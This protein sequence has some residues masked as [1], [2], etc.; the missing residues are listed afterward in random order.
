MAHIRALSHQHPAARLKIIEANSYH[1]DLP[2]HRFAALLYWDDFGVG[3]DE[4]QRYLLRRIRTWLQPE[5]VAL[6]DIYT[7]WHAARSIGKGWRVGR[8]TREYGFDG[9]RCRRIDRW[10]VEG[11][12]PVEQSLRC[13]APADLRLL[14]QGT[15][16][17]LT[18][19]KVGGMMDY[20]SGCY[21]EAVPLEQAMVY[22][23]I[24]KP[25]V[26]ARD[27]CGGR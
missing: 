4:E 19:I 5:G 17:T 7:P 1:V 3:G 20:A 23:A 10:W 24:L 13:Y 2:P 18:G 16:L 14:L 12:E 22:T 11:E 9:D 15:G 21:F 25:L 6:I 27:F 26:A 8:A